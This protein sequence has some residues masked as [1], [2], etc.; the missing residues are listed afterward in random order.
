MNLKSKILGSADWR[1]EKVHVPE[2]DTD[3]Y[4]RTLSGHDRTSLMRKMDS[5]DK[6]GQCG[7][8]PALI[9]SIALSDEAGN[10]IFTDMD[11]EALGGKNTEVL[12]RL[13]ET[14]LTFNGMMPKSEDEVKKVSRRTRN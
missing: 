5:L 13:A 4:V 12:G 1:T 7:D 2:W 6:A 14:A 9:L 11:V 3:V 10:R 8:L